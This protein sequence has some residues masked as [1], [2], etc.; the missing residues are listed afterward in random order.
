MIL[1]I[2]YKKVRKVLFHVYFSFHSAFKVNIISN[3]DLHSLCTLFFFQSALNWSQIKLFQNALPHHKFYVH[4]VATAASHS[5]VLQVL[6][7]YNNNKQKKSNQILNR[8][9]SSIKYLLQCYVSSS[10]F[11]KRIFIAI[12]CFS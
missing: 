7:Q 11:S 6:V 8:V 12:A 2:L 3:V 1:F 4:T 10:S 9:S 5:Y